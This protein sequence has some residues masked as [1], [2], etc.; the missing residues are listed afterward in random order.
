MAAAFSDGEFFESDSIAGLFDSLE[1]L[2]RIDLLLLDLNLPGAHG[3]S[4]LAHLRGSHPQLPVVVVSA[5]DDAPTVRQ[6]L[7]TVPPLPT[8]VIELLR[9]V[10]D[11]NSTAA[12]VARIASSDPALAAALL[13][14]VNSSAFALKRKV[15]PT[16]RS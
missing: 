6:A 11:P 2:P 15:T 10:Q 4:A 13:R 16:L 12:G 5:T 1:C 3:F 8:V 9:E 14:T 7:Q